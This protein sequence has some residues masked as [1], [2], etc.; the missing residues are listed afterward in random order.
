VRIIQVAIR[1]QLQAVRIANR[2]RL[3]FLSSV[4][5]GYLYADITAAS[6]STLFPAPNANELVQIDPK[7]ESSTNRQTKI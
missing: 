4:E 6:S 3:V 7:T 2:Q 1:Q 5:V